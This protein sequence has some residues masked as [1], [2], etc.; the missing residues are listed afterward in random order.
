RH[1]LRATGPPLSQT[2]KGERDVRLDELRQ[3]WSRN[4]REYGERFFILA[5]PQE[6][7]RSRI[8]RLRIARVDGE[9]D[10]GVLQ[11]LLEKT[12]VDEHTRETPMPLIGIRVERYRP[13]ELP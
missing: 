3:D 4:A 7:L 10:G 9:G 8:E 12:H 5:H 6:C 2:E 1:W 11:G 13:A